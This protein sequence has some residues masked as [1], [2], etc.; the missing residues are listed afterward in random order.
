MK[1]LRVTYTAGMVNIGSDDI[2]YTYIPGMYTGGRAGVGLQ[3]EAHVDRA[4]CERMCVRIAEAV[5]EF[6]QGGIKRQTEESAE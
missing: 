1:P 6:G 2:S 5:A 4:A 3:V